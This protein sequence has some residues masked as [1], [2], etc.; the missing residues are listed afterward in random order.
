MARKMKIAF[1]TVMTALLLSGCNLS[2]VSDL[3]CLPRRSEEYT[4]LQTVITKAMNGM[5]YCAPISGDNQQTVQVADLNG[6]GEPEYLVFAKGTSE[7]PLQIFVFAGDGENYE[8]LDTIESTGSAFD[9][10]EYIQMDGVPGYE[11]VVGRQV[12]DQVLRSVSV[13]SMIN[14]QMEQLMS[15]NYS[16]YLC[17]DLDRN[18][19]NELF[20]LRPGDGTN[21]VAVLYSFVGR[22]LERSQEVN[23]SEPAESIKRLMLGRLN[24]GAV[25]VYVASSVTG[26]DG[27]ITDVYTLIDGQL[28]NVSLSNE[29][30]TSVQTLRNYY[31][32]ADDIDNDGILELPSLITMQRTEDDLNA[33]DQYIIRWY[34]MTTDGSEVDKQYTYHN[35]FGGWYMELDGELA[36]RFTVNQKGSSYEFSLWNE[37]FTTSEKLMTVY[38]LTGQKR[39]EQAVA[40]NR[41]VLHRSEST[42]YA[43]DL[44]AASVAYGMTKESLI[45]SFHL[46]LQDWKT[47]ET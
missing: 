27:I 42:V 24:D 47:G 1:L 40:E 43:A 34:A 38:V 2:T 19:L 15:A 25:A 5:E 28:T 9:R 21:G 26:S 31:V 46:I 32:Y 18:G 13:Y 41:F 10:V 23:M 22:S 45:S 7:K 12:S 36:D 6:D 17:S 14:G 44:E 30:G 4:N 3:Y 16:E 29:S 39:E 37:D 11:I 20:L 35:F 33:A 8:L